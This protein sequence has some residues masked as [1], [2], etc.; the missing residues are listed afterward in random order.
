MSKNSVFLHFDV[1]HLLRRFSR[2]SFEK[3]FL[4]EICA[5]H[6]QCYKFMGYFRGKLCINRASWQKVL[7][8]FFLDLR[9]SLQFYLKTLWKTLLIL[10][11]FLIGFT[12]FE[13][14]ESLHKEKI[15]AIIWNTISWEVNVFMCWAREEKS[16]LFKNSRNGHSEINAACILESSFSCYFSAFL[17]WNNGTPV[18]TI[19]EFFAFKM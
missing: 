15:W 11:G 8:H 2:P 18:L 6:E 13:A 17:Q 3:T 9:A 1:S 19:W 5:A 16:V 10:T 12:V 7:M 4:S 14:H